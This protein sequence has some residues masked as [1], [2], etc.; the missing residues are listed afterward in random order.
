[1]ALLSIKDLSIKF[2]GDPLLDAVNLNIEYGDR[3]CLVGRNGTG[4]S[5]FLKILAGIED[6]DSGEIINAPGIK[7]AYLP[8]DI[9]VGLTGSVREIANATQNTN[10]EQLIRAA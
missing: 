7:T 9:P 4:K 5:T 8:Q 2:G 1:M 3:A 6:P 10:D